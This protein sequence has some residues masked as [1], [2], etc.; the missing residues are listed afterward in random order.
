[1]PSPPT[2]G[3]L[4]SQGPGLPVATACIRMRR[5]RPQEL[6]LDWSPCS[7]PQG[8]RAGGDGEGSGDHGPAGPGGGGSAAPRGLQQAGEGEEHRDRAAPHQVGP[9]VLA[10]LRG[11]SAF[12]QSLLPSNTLPPCSWDRHCSPH[13]TQGKPCVLTILLAIPQHRD[14]SSRKHVRECSL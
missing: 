6:D 10:L 2:V 7:S 12:P 5:H 4:A 9:A 3:M 14:V 8:A 11:G 13:L 1:M